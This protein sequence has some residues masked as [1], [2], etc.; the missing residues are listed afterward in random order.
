MDEEGKL[1]TLVK[2][3]NSIMKGQ[4][5]LTFVE[6]TNYFYDKPEIDISEITQK[7][8]LLRK[9]YMSEYFID[10]CKKLG[11]LESFGI[12]RVKKIIKMKL[13]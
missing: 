5:K 13:G 2:F 9:R 11:L 6:M 4:E 8:S 10:E 7:T 1:K 3:Y 12:R